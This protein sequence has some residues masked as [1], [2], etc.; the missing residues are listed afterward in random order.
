LPFQRL[1]FGVGGRV[2]LLAG[3][4]ADRLGAGARV[5]QLGFI[6]LQRSVGLVLQ[7]L[8][9]GQIALDLVLACIDRPATRG[10]ATRDTIR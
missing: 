4:V 9:L 7:L 10:S 5:G 6:G 3:L 1:A 2:Q 8:R